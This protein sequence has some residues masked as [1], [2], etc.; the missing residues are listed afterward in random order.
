MPHLPWLNREPPRP[1]HRAGG[2]PP[3]RLKPDSG[4]V[5]PLLNPPRGFHSGQN[6]WETQSHPSSLVCP[7]LFLLP[8]SLEPRSLPTAP[9]TCRTQSC[10]GAFASAV[11][12][13]CRAYLYPHG[14]CFHPPAVSVFSWIVQSAPLGVDCGMALS[15]DF[16]GSLWEKRK[17]GKEQMDVLFILNPILTERTAISPHTLASRLQGAQLGV[18]GRDVT[19]QDSV[20]EQW[21]KA[22]RAAT[23][24]IVSGAA[25]CDDAHAPLHRCRPGSG[26]SG[27]G[28]HP[29]GNIMR[30]P[31]PRPPG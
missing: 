2:F 16:R 4:H 12:A 26:S 5:P 27:P 18:N 28:Q 30:G 10:P 20:P 9:Q 31:E 15:L 19:P 8:P 6:A 13:A 14:R 29:D 21:T 25:C 1:H 11:P 7:Q 17:S 24:G 3:Q 23:R 22:S